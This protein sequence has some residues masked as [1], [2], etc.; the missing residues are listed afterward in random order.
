VSVSFDQA[1]VKQ[2]QAEVHEAY[3]RQGSRL[4][5]TVRTKSEIR[6]AS[7]VFQKVGRGTAASKSRNGIVPVMNLDHTN[8]ECFLQDHY[9]GDWIDRFDELKTNVDERGVVAHAGAFA[10]G[11]KTDELIIAAMD[12]TTVEAIGT[13]AGETDNDGMTRNKV[14]LAFQALGAN[15]VPDDNNRYAVVGWKQWSELLAI[16]EFANAD[17]VGP[18]ALPWKGTTQ[19]KQWLGALWM[20][21]S[22]LTKVGALRYCYFYHKTAI[23]HAAASEV[24][25]DVTWHGDR[26]ASFVNSMMSQGASLIDGQGVVRM[27]AKE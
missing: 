6:G 23:G 3:Q 9:A 16:P 12:A 13:N 18:D 1:F 8:V 19:A 10:L 11:R 14:L 22:G 26:A 21:H 17:Y 4:R 24:V 25:T 5:P 7:T 20:P 15:D 2:F 27:R